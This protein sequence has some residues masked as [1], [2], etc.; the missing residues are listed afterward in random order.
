[1]NISQGWKG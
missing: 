1:V